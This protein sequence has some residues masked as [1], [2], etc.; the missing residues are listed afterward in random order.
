MGGEGGGGAG[1]KES[2]SIGKGR[3]RHREETRDLR[4]EPVR[5]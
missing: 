4:S 1:D 3:L 2:K 5:E